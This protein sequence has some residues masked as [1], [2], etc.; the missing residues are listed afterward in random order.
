MK[1]T[2]IF[3]LILIAIYSCPSVSTQNLPDCDTG[4]LFKNRVRVTRQLE[5]LEPEVFVLLFLLRLQLKYISMNKINAKAEIIVVHKISRDY[6][7][8]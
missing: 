5:H 2:R 6:I 7:I 4:K 8:I 1:K 3:S